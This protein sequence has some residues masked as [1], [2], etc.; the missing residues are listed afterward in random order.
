MHWTVNISLPCEKQ[1]IR[2]PTGSAHVLHRG[3]AG[4][5]A[6]LA[7]FRTNPTMLMCLGVLTTFFAADLASLAADLKHLFEKPFI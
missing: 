3:S 2:S 6:P 1:K 7:D 5:F 4:F